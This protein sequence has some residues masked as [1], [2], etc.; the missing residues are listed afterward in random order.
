MT[1]TPLVSCEVALALAYGQL[2]DP[3]IPLMLATTV[4]VGMSSRQ[5]NIS[6]AHSPINDI[7]G[8]LEILNGR[9]E[10]MRAMAGIPRNLY[11]ARS[12]AHVL[13]HLTPEE[14][15]IPPG[16]F[17]VRGFD[18]AGCTSSRQY[19]AYG[20][21]VSNFC[22][23]ADGGGSVLQSCSS[24][25]GNT[26][27]TVRGFSDDACQTLVSTTTVSQKACTDNGPNPSDE[28]V[29]TSWEC[30]PGPVTL[31]S[32]YILEKDS[33]SPT[34]EGD[35]F[36]SGFRNNFCFTFWSGHY[37]KFVYPR[38]SVYSKADCSGAVK[39]RFTMGKESSCK[40]R[41]YDDDWAQPLY[42][43]SYYFTAQD[44]G[45]GIGNTWGDDPFAVDDTYSY[46]DDA[47]YYSVEAN[48][49][50]HIVTNK[51]N[52]LTFEPIA[53]PTTAPTRRPTVRPSLSMLALS[54]TL[55][56][57]SL[58]SVAASASP[59]SV[60]QS[61][62]ASSSPSLL[63]SIEATTR[64]PTLTPT[65]IPSASPTIV[66]TTLLPTSRNPP[67]S[68]SSRA[69]SSP[70]R[71]PTG[72]TTASPL[73]S[74]PSLSPELPSKPSAFPSQSPTFLIYD[75]TFDA[76]LY[77]S[78]LS[79]KDYEAA[80]DDHD[81]VLAAAMAISL[82]IDAEAV[83]IIDVFEQSFFNT[84]AEMMP[85][86]S[87]RLTEGLIV[88]I[89]RTIIVDIDAMG[90][91]SSDVA[92]EAFKTILVDAV[93][94][95]SLTATIHDCAT[96]MS[97]SA[98]QSTSAESVDVASPFMYKLQQPLPSKDKP[99]PLGLIIG[100]AISA[101]KSS[102][103]SSKEDDAFLKEFKKFMKDPKALQETYAQLQNPESLQQVQA[104][105]R[106]PSFLSEVNRLKSNPLYKDALAS[107]QEMY[108]DPAKAAKFLSA[109]SAARRDEMST[110]QLGMSELSK[111]AKNPKL[112]A[113]ALEDLKNPEI[114][115]EVQ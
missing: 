37:V 54:P 62:L 113:E 14:A 98:L 63:P 107:V 6:E 103:S 57:F 41:T 111:V 2:Q 12:Q 4:S 46:D 106:D 5:R 93:R 99:L 86:R 109:M 7:S 70:M 101:A 36:F 83:A 73:T 74:N 44:D 94:S 53:S 69:P 31:P 52:L 38:L 79:M 11:P 32:P 23:R 39:K 16:F 1:T 76:F 51:I 48:Y 71:I 92:F 64:R 17:V 9:A 24:S 68:R 58:P 77:I 45:F 21:V 88:V 29:S 20:N 110:A 55:S 84:S 27:L 96:V 15:S 89:F 8:I 108:S 61:V 115:A 19:F 13:R 75:L 97:V 78:G 42:Y 87:F 65:D 100:M 85:D 22:M 80:Q 105:M 82:Q 66:P 91:K 43:Y 95:G 33:N 90:F 35:T 50:Q 114:A 59:S 34:C 72:R 81:R 3:R 102:K 30:I 26:T 104:M 49:V 47:A 40:A 10:T 25:G 18:A 28:P 67:Y 60:P 56:P 112:M